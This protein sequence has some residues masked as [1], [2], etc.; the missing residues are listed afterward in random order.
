M[1]STAQVGSN[2]ASWLAS[3]PYGGGLP[4]TAVGQRGSD[5]SAYP[6]GPAPGA[7]PQIPYGPPITPLDPNTTAML[8]VGGL[9]LLSGGGAL[10]GW[11]LTTTRTGA[12]LGALGGLSYGAANLAYNT[13]QLQG[14]WQ[15]R[16]Q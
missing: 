2:D 16:S 15:G 9:V 4:A 6:T 5:P 14:G 10:L 13:A 7:P 8:L 1:S 12:L 3:V 11:F